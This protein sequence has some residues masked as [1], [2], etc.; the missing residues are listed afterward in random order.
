M[1]DH[2]NIFMCLNRFLFPQKQ[3]PGIYNK[4]APQTFDYCIVFCN[5]V[6]PYLKTKNKPM[7]NYLGKLLPVL[8]AFILL[9]SA[10]NSSR[11][12]MHHRSV[13]NSGYKGY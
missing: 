10:C 2:S 1:H 7:K 5:T 11:H 8:L 3:V 9:L 12:S 4:G 6:Q 13:N